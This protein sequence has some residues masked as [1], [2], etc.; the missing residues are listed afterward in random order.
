MLPNQSAS[1]HRAR[2]LDTTRRHLTDSPRREL[3]LAVNIPS[4]F[5]EV[6]TH[7][8]AAPRDRLTMSRL[9][10]DAAPTTSGVTRLADQMA[11]AGLAVRDKS[12][13]DRRSIHV[14][15]ITEILSLPAAQAPPPPVGP[16]PP[17][18]PLSDSEIRVLRYLPTHLTGPCRRA[19]PL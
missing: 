3:E 11:E 9:S 18:E 8:A 7:V 13:S 19:E 16:R 2:R 17:V 12:P 6:L 4:V 5:F 15:M 1:S 10:A 14:V